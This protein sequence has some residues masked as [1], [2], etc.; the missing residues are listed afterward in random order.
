MIVFMIILQVFLIVA[1]IFIALSAESVWT[2]IW[3]LLLLIA[4]C[5]TLA[6]YLP[7]AAKRSLSDYLDKQ[8]E[9]NQRKRK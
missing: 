6:K 9:K 8:A 1:A 2:L 5:I 3:S 7:W 4:A